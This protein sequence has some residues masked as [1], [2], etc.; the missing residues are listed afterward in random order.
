ML[1]LCRSRGGGAVSGHLPVQF[2]S[3]STHIRYGG[4]GLFTTTPLRLEAKM[5]KVDPY[6]DGEKSWFGADKAGKVEAGFSMA[7]MNE[8]SSKLSKSNPRPINTTAHDDDAIRRSADSAANMAASLEDH[9]TA[10]HSTDSVALPHIP[11]ISHEELLEK[12]REF[13][14]VRKQ[15]SQQTANVERSRRL[16]EIDQMRRSLPPQKFKEFMADLEKVD[17]QNQA[18]MEKM[19][20]MSPHQLFRYQRNKRWWNQLWVNVNFAFSIFC[21]VGT[22][23]I[24]YYLLIEFFVV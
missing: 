5:R 3:T 21:S 17:T 22:F 1:S 6:L 7:V 23:F 12:V 9:A 11:G 8:L 18:E 20:A 13:E 24:F 14:M 15:D 10:A 4:A 16:K 2:A 19:A